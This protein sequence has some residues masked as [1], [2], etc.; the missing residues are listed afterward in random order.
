MLRLRTAVAPLAL[1]ASILAGVGPLSAQRSPFREDTPRVDAVVIRGVTGVDMN[2]LRRGL[3]T[4]ASRCRSIFFK[5]FCWF[6]TTSFFVEKHDIEPRALP[7]D[8]LRIRV[9]LWRRGWRHSTVATAVEPSGTGSG[10]RV[11]FD[12]A[13]GPPTI[14]RAVELRQGDPELAGRQIRNAELPDTGQPLNV[15]EMDTVRVRLLEAFWARGYGDA[16]VRDTARLLDSLNAIVEVQLEPG[17]RTTV[18]QILV[19]GNER[20]SDR[21]VRDAMPMREGRLYRPMEAAESQR[22]LHLTGL[23]QQ[24][25]VDVPEQADT[26]KTVRVEVREAPFRMLRARVGFTTI[27]FLQT[28]AQ[29]TQYNWFGGGRRIDVTGVLGR[30]LAKRLE[31][32]FPF[33]EGAPGSPS[34]L[35]EEAFL[36]PTWQASVQLTQPSFPAASNSLGLGVFTHRRVEPGVVVDRGYGANVTFTQNLARRAPLSLVYRYEQNT[37]L[38]GDVYFCVNYG[39]CDEPTIGALQGRQSLSPLSVSGFMDRVDDQLVRTSGYTIRLGLDHASGLT[40]S[41]F[42]YN[43]ADAEITRDIQLGR[44]TLA[45]RVRGGW[46]KALSTTGSA[47]GGN[48]GDAILH[49]TTRFYAGGARSVRGFAENQLG[50]RILTVD[51]IVLVGPQGSDDARDAENGPACTRASIV[52]GDCDP[53]PVSSAE[54][55]PRPIG[56]TRLMAMSVEYRRPIWGNFIG[57]VFVDGARVGDPALAELGEARTAVTPGFGVR[58]RS[59]IGPVRIDLGIR[60]AAKEDLHVVTQVTEDGVNRL[61]RL[62]TEKRYDPLEGHSGFLAQVTSRLTLHLSLGEAF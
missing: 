18:G 60:P 5:P 4:K 38:A 39:V 57:A 53:N 46:V 9:H 32:N 30:L 13:Q 50:P 37:V 24:A 51:P 21:T 29:F 23:F 2:E 52:S 10:V 1:A 12:V 58:Y 25:L 28:Q 22:A 40:A 33:R 8:E 7:H 36:R 62:K 48:E 42:R 35:T 49:P 3:V 56:G 47:V 19:D 15:L 43:R 17:R 54:F 11:T 6:T 41:N 26:A 31:G 61:V 20:V 44:A 14:V 55:N 16:V 27:D 59:P 45:G 34:G